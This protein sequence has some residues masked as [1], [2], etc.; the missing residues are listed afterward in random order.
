MLKL[1]HKSQKSGHYK[2]YRDHGRD[3]GYILKEYWRKYD[4][5]NPRRILE[6]TDKQTGN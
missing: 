6:L 2:A 5:E 4:A 3:N 1:N